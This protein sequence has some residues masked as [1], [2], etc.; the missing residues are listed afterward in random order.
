MDKGLKLKKNVKYF[1]KLHCSGRN[2]CDGVNPITLNGTATGLTDLDMYYSKVSN[3]YNAYRQIQDE[4]KYPASSLGFAKQRPEWEI[5]GAFKTDPIE[6]SS[7]SLS[8]A[9]VTVTSG[10]AVSTTT[11]TCVAVLVFPFAS[12]TVQVTV[13]LPTG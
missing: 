2:C 6:I 13:V 7:I 11:T 4:D 9:V 12:V 10:F 1:L 3:A 8:N 5:V